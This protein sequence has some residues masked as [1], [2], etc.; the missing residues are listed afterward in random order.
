ME[1][2]C[3]SLSQGSVGTCF[4]TNISVFNPW[5]I[6]PSDPPAG[7][8]DAL[9]RSKHGEGC[10]LFLSRP[11]PHPRPPVLQVCSPPKGWH[12]LCDISA[13]PADPPAHTRVYV[14]QHRV[15]AATG[16]CQVA[17]QGWVWDGQQPACRAAMVA[18][19]FRALG[20]ATLLSTSAE[21][22]I[23]FPPQGLPLWAPTP[24]PPTTQASCPRSQASS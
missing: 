21:A 7:G 14:S 15:V 18:L 22:G 20:E 23:E 13:S 4:V 9:E 17:S 16:K 24:R 8:G 5:R 12:H 11:P 1:L 3:V 2:A 10:G 6:S 19:A